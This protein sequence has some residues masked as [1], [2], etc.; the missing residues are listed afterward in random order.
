MTRTRHPQS[1]ETDSTPQPDRRPEDAPLAKT[2]ADDP[3]EDKQRTRGER[4]RGKWTARR[5]TRTARPRRR[6]A[7]R[8]RRPR[9]GFRRNG[10]P[11][12]ACHLVW[13]T[14]HPCY[15]LGCR[16]RGQENATQTQRTA[17]THPSAEMQGR[18]GRLM[19]G[20]PVAGTSSNALHVD[21]PPGSSVGYFRLFLGATPVWRPQSSF[22][23]FGRRSSVSNHKG[24]R[25]T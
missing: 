2:P 20:L 10:K 9:P 11:L 24:S 22:V 4:R 19:E 12:G 21:A 16:A 13:M 3:L 23:V 6:R 15:T 14:L 7:A 25:T 8:P 17:Q 18:A 1:I 5:R